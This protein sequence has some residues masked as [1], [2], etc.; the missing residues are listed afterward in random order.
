MSGSATLTMVTSISSMNVPRQT[1][2]SG[3]HLRMCDRPF[4]L[5]STAQVS[6]CGR[7]RPPQIGPLA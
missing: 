2:M 4:R 7:T 3:N 1:V 6:P 5:A